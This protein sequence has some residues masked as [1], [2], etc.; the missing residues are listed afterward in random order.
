LADESVRSTRASFRSTNGS[1][2]SLRWA[3][4]SLVC[5]HRSASNT[6]HRCKGARAASARMPPVV[7]ERVPQAPSSACVS[8]WVI[9]FAEPGRRRSSEA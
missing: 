3:S 8:S 4:C 7:G 6:R 9:A 2:G 1:S 5:R